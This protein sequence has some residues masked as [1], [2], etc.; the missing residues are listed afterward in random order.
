MKKWIIGIFLILSTLFLT[1]CMSDAEKA[2][3]GTWEYNEEH[4]KTMASEQRLTIVWFFNGGTFSYQACCFNT[5]EEI[6]GRYR[7]KNVE[8][9]IVTLEL[10]NTRGSNFRLNTELRIKI[11]P[12]TGELT[13]TNAG[14][15]R[16]LGPG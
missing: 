12:E 4:L 14:P 9:N 1:A 10:Y 15:F 3:Q 7:I 16:K 11:D 6:A 5:D 13:I 8:G 2:I